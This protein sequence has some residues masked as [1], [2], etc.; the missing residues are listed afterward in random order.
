MSYNY[1]QVVWGSNTASLSFTSA[2]SFR[3][4][5]I[6]AAI[7][8]L[9]NKNVKI[10][11]IGCGG[12]QFIRAVK[13][14]RPDTICHGCDISQVAL[15][16]ARALKDGVNYDLCGDKL[17]Y[18][19]QS[20]DLVLILDVLEHVESPEAMV[21]EVKRVL[22]SNGLFFTFIPCEG[23][24]T[25][26]IFWL[27]KFGL[28]KNITRQCAGHINQWSRKKWITLIESLG[29]KKVKVNYSEH[30]I[31]QFLIVF[32][33]IMLRRQAQK[34]PNKEVNNEEFYAAAY[35]SV[36]GRLFKLIKNCVNILINV[37]TRLLQRV[38]SSNLHA[39][40]KK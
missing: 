24:Y 10:L 26:F 32:T 21:S 2:T 22:K 33:F 39:L 9:P 34:F 15:E 8:S 13:Y 3:L 12:G 20:F 29:L 19:D 7:D 11:E 28:L 4:Q 30:I 16:K 27:Q 14:Y 31:G 35:S 18:A 5:N 17:T 23:D 40:F 36:W 37:E 25:N 38:P 1:E 6:L